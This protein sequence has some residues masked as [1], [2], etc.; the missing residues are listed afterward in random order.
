METLDQ[1]EN[2]YVGPRT[3]QPDER[4]KF[5]GRSRE[6]RDLTA[7]IVSNR[8]VLFYAPS[9][10]GKSSLLNTMITPML[11]EAGFEVLPIGRVS[12]YGG[13][14][15]AS[16]NIYVYNL[17]LSLHKS[18]VVPADC[19]TLTLSQFLDNLV[20]HENGNHYYDQRYIY[21]P[22]T[23]FR[24]RVLIVD[25][26]EELVTS[27]TALW[28]QRTAFFQQLVEAMLLDEQLWVVLTLRE[29]YVARFDPYAHLLPNRLRHRYHMERLTRPAAIEAIQM[30][31]A[32]IRPFEPEAIERLAD[33]LLSLRS[34]RGRDSERFAQFIEPVQ[35][36]AVCYQM[37][38]ELRQQPGTS[39]N[40][41]DVECFADVDKALIN[42]YEDTVR[43]TVRLTGVS[44]VALRDWF[45][46]ELIT[47]AGTRNMVYRG[48][49]MTGDLPTSV[50]DVILT[51]Y[52]VREEVRPGGLW[53]ELAHEHL[54][55]PILAANG[56]WRLRQPLPQL[57]QRWEEAGHS[58]EFLLQGH[59]L[60]RLTNNSEWQ[61]L[62]PIVTEYVRASQV[63]Q[64]KTE[65]EIAA[66]REAIRQREIEQQ[67][68]LA[69]E[70][71][72]RAQ[73]AEIAAVGQRKLMRTAFLFGAIA[74]ILAVLVGA[75]SLYAS[76]RATEA[77]D[78]HDAVLISATIASAA[79]ATAA[80][81]ARLAVV[82]QQ[83]AVAGLTAVAGAFQVAS[84]SLATQA[85]HLGIRLSAT[86]ALITG[87]T[88][89][90]SSPVSTPSPPQNP[91]AAGTVTALE[92]E[93]AAVQATQTVIALRQESVT[94][95]NIGHS[96]QG[97][98]IQAVHIGSGPNKLVFVGGIHSGTAPNTVTL[99]EATIDYFTKHAAEIPHTVTLIVVS[100]L[101]PDSPRTSRLEGR[102]NANGVDL[103]RNWHCNWSSAPMIRGER[104]ENAGG[105]E[106][107]SEPETQALAN[108]ILRGRPVAVIFWGAPD[109]SRSVSPGGCPNVRTETQEL[110]ALYADASGYSEVVL[111]YNSIQGGAS[112]W[113][114]YINIPSLFVL[115][116]NIIDPDF[117]RHLSAIK[118]VV[119]HYS[120]P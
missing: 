24:P 104:R 17:L 6:S 81:N 100:N 53:Y 102:Y 27:N 58:E 1:D 111:A 108:F 39:I 5:F 68:A 8:L 116:P 36:Q 70:Q 23:I 57:A 119:E 113:L 84:A 97:R 18:D 74:L 34:A 71:R 22:D 25:Q 16:A 42:L 88:S 91:M 11:T 78:A 13:E 87:P 98:P 65:A 79:E 110:A 28:P 93:L 77:Q 75:A 40:V 46:N 49:G 7:L 15:T 120:R 67:H 30:P 95:V 29:D 35:L 37:W 32:T 86:P 2:P 115:L 112:N 72:K 107:N 51:R 9:G 48:E 4:A 56:T 66:E 82:E 54:V 21:P 47:E 52:I 14:E 73:E 12:G 109:E 103:N 43:H 69:V 20:Q 3:F 50:A 33:N 90:V 85:A 89:P 94:T 41:N 19:A 26:F 106:P 62:G 114:D 60:G 10:A 76:N 92:I 105:T 38:E 44:E 45:E 83:T 55:Q 99:A 61:L 96:V 117:D 31:V 63:A 80:Y 59:Q 101:N 118:R 64:Q